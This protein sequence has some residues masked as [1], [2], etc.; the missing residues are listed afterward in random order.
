MTEAEAPYLG[1]ALA[2]RV[3]EFIAMR[4]DLHP[5]PELAFEE[6]RTSGLVAR[7]LEEWGY[8]VERRLGGTG[9]VGTLRRGRGARRL[10]LRAD[11]DALRMQEHGSSA[12]EAPCPAARM[13]AG[14]TAT[15]PPY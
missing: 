5:H 15:P 4:R 1:Q 10:S 13:P 8:E 3:A 11:M 7:K 9:V 12:C 14:M 6:H 2:G